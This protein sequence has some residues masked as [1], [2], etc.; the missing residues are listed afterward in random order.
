VGL[1]GIVRPSYYGRFSRGF[2]AK[3]DLL[4]IIIVLLVKVV[5]GFM[6][7]EDLGLDD[8]GAGSTGTRARQAVPGCGKGK[9]LLDFMLFIIGL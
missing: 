4:N 1:G 9:I 8:Q 3:D 7:A 5:G 2:H 6:E